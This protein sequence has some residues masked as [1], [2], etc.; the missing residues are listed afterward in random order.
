[1]N[2]APLPRPTLRPPPAFLG[3]R[4]QILLGALVAVA[5]T[6]VS[7]VDVVAAERTIVDASGRSVT[8]GDARRIVTIGGDVTET[9]Y[10][11]GA[12]DRVV[13]RD[14]T[15]VYPPAVFEKPDVGYM[16]ALSAEGVLS[17]APDLILAAEGAGPEA[18]LDILKS[19]AV[20]IVF[21]PKGETPAG[22]AAK[23]RLI[24]AALGLEEKGAALAGSVG[25]D[26]EAVEAAIAKLPPESRKRVV[27]LL[28]FQGGKPLAAGSGTAADAM[29]GLA[30][31]VN[32]LHEIAGYRPAAEEAIAAAAP[33]AVLMMTRGAEDAPKAEEIFAAPAFAATPAAR[34][35]ALIVM[36]AALLNFGPRAAAAARDLAHRLYPDLALPTLAAGR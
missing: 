31:G 26:F 16:R 35:Q 24:A 21:V 22:A 5:M 19:A 15:S 29:I 34:S 3:R 18:T 11:L 36:D 13:A 14:Q 32:P 25:A 27:F 6:L 10:A 20:P 7:L 23:I 8:V 33:D 30:G 4:G 2:A 1:M 28:S 17:V 9:V 12:A